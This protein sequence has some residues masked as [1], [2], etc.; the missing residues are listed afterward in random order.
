MRVLIITRIFPNCAEPALAPYNRL[1]FG[2]LAK[3]CHV[4]VLALVPWLPGRRWLMPT[5]TA[6]LPA[7]EYVDGMYV[8]HPRVL[9]A[10]KLGRPLSGPL[11]TASL[12]PAVA[13]MKG[14]VDVVLGSFAY[15]DGWA[16]VALSKWLGVPALIKVHG[17]DINVYG[18]DPLLR[19]HLRWAF[20]RAAA[21]VGPSQ[22]LVDRAIALGASAERSRMIPNGID[23]RAFTVRDRR[24][25]RQALGRG[26]DGRRWIVFVGRLSEAKG[27]LDLL[28]AFREVHRRAP[29]VALVM[30]GDGVD[31]QRCEALAEGLPVV[32]AGERRPHDVPLWV[33]ASDVVTLPSHNEGTPNAILEALA[34]GRPAVASDVGGIPAVM[35]NPVFGEMV[36]AR[37]PAALADAL[38]GVLSKPH[39]PWQIATSASV[40]GWDESARLLQDVLS[41]IVI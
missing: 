32:F 23:K 30:L 10:P 18:D 3:R 36:P 29:D 19:P 33:G 24:R 16:A 4:E 12:L 14:R 41:A 7:E 8:R 25:C 31:R 13:P 27:A 22:A 26:D 21:V 6:A 39:D 15:P 37:S 1:Q 9:Y 35:S 38:L 40:I 5:P 11:Y 2:E 17:S 34:C 20:R 28:A